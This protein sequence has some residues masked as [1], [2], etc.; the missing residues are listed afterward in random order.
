MQLGKT[1]I[2]QHRFHSVRVKIK[3]IDRKWDIN[4][5]EFN[6]G[7]EVSLNDIAQVSLQTNQPL[8]YDPFVENSKTGNAILVDETSYNTVGALMFL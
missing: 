3:S 8:N 1:Y 4:T 5:L 7:E 6:I 2:L